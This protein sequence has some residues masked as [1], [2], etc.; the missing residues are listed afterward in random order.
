MC[1]LKPTLLLAALLLLIPLTSHAQDEVDQA[2]LQA[3]NG[4]LTVATRHVPPFA[5]RDDQGNWSG[6][7]IDLLQEIVA[8]LNTNAEQPLQVE[9]R[10]LTLAEMLSAV[11]LGEVDMAVAALT[12]NF[13]REE[14][15]D[16]SHPFHNSGL[17]IAVTA[18]ES[19]GW[20]AV[21]ERIFSITFLQVIAG[22]FTMLL[23][24]G[25]LMYFFERRKNK[26]QFGGGFWRGLGAGMWW[27]VVTLTTVGYGDKAPT[28]LPGRLIAVLWMISGLLIISAFTAAMTS[29][30]T[31]GELRSRVSGPE[32][33]PRVQ[34][35]TVQNSTSADY[36]RNRNIRPR[37][38]PDL[39]DAITELREGRVA[40]VV[41]DAPLLQYQ[42]MQDYPK[43]HV[44]PG[45]FQRQDYSIALP[46]GS[47][48]RE[49]VNR[50]VVRTITKSA[51]DEKLTS[52]LGEQ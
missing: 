52:Y 47:P 44:L 4:K 31:V 27:S 13:E 20:F 19:D 1:L 34:V 8:D 36:L 41:Y 11:E 6:I 30:L 28:T 3:L 37:L 39:T 7:A 2:A 40:A 38:L 9:Y 25:V 46:S 23:V 49:P 17:G 48:L 16:F 43:L 15:M 42:I 29:A 32:D 50:T 21:L 51:W 45:T 22:L 10:D 18:E 26:S 12:V 24:S 33:L 14:R 5:I 35:A